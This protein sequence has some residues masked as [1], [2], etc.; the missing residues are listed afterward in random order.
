MVVLCILE[1]SFYLLFSFIVDHI[2]NRLDLV[3]FLEIFGCVLVIDVMKNLID[4]LLESK[5]MIQE[6]NMIVKRSEEKR[7]I[8]GVPTVHSI[9]IYKMCQGLDLPVKLAAEPE[10]KIWGAT[11]KSQNRENRPK[12]KVFSKTM[13]MFCEAL[14]IDAEIS[15][16]TLKEQHLL[17]NQLK[18]RKHLPIV[19]SIMIFKMCKAL[20][21][22][23]KL[24]A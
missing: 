12:P 18:R 23:A 21:L 24:D 9:M 22:S 14:D 17:E 13:L 2:Q 3:S 20:G 6:N 19:H 1:T 10:R 15:H 8:I 11:G 5:T 16:L 7:E 4:I